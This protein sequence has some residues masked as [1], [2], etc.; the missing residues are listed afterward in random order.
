MNPDII[1]LLVI[2]ASIM[3]AVKAHDIYKWRK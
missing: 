3:I 1:T 2:F